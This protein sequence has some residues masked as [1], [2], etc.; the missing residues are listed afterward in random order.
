MNGPTRNDTKRSWKLKTK[1]NAFS[2][3][4]THNNIVCDG[5]PFTKAVRP[6][7]LL[8]EQRDSSDQ[9]AIVLSVTHNVGK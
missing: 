3:S 4:T 8:E 1:L 9:I 5:R 2:F 6:H 7:C